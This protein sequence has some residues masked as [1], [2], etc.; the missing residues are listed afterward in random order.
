LIGKDPPL[1]HPPALR[2]TVT[3]PDWVLCHAFSQHPYFI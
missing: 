3:I 2:G 1:T